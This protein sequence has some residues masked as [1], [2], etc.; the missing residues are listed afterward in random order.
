MPLLVLFGREANHVD[1]FCNYT[2]PY[3]TG[4]AIKVLTDA[5]LWMFTGFTH[6][7]CIAYLYFALQGSEGWHKSQLFGNDLSLC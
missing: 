4:P 3:V 1:I 6:F 7:T 5:M 2:V